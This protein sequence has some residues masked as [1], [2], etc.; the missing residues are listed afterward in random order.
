MSEDTTTPETATPEADEQVGEEL[1]AQLEPG[2]RLGFVRGIAPSK[3]ASR[4]A[5]ATRSELGLVP[6]AAAFSPR[7]PESDDYDMLL[8]RTLP[9]HVPAGSS[10]AETGNGQAPAVP[11]TRRAIRLYRE[12]I[13]L[14][15]HREHELAEQ[16]EISVADLALVPLIDHP[17]H[18]P[19][20]PAAQPWA[21]PEWMPKHAR[22][23][24]EIVATGA[25]A[26][27]LPLPLARHLSSK[28]QHALLKV[29][30]EPGLELTTVWA[31]WDIARDDDEM[32]QLAGILRGRTARSSRE[33]SPVSATKVAAAKAV[34]TPQ[35]K[36]KLPKLKHNSRGA[37]LQLSQAKREREAAIKRLEKRKK[38]H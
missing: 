26:M 15:V 18:A 17:D 34:K 21:E 4:Y 31:T 24:L 35:P 27:L 6:V 8:E 29:V 14:V 28:K 36:K 32:Q 9:G 2:I 23:A 22:G 37:Q 30:G 20:W 38:K 10:Q 12:N 7:N 33:G 11:A 13:A 5:K 19:E 3:W 16:T 25:G 1:E